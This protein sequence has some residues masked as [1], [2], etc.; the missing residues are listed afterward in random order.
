[1]ATIVATHRPALRKPTAKPAGSTTV[2]TSF[3]GPV[4]LPIPWRPQAGSG[5][6]FVAVE[7]RAGL[8]LLFLERQTSRRGGWDRGANALG[9][10]QEIRP[11]RNRFRHTLATPLLEQGATSEQVADI[12]GNSLAVVRKH[13]GK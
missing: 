7:R 5:R 13:Y 4:Y 9:V 12:L 1:M 2:T 10:F 6:A 8:S 3:G 11:T